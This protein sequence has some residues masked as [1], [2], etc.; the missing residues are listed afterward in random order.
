[1]MVQSYEKLS[2]LNFLLGHTE[3][4]YKSF[5]GVEVISHILIVVHYNCMYRQTNDHVLFCQGFGAKDI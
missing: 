3:Y 4:M 5:Y 2:S 1:M